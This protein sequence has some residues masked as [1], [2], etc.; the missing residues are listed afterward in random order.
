MLD[1][2]NPSVYKQLYR[3]AKAKLKLRIKATING[4]V[5]V[6]VEITQPNPS[7]TVSSSTS[8]SKPS[9][10]ATGHQLQES[11]RSKLPYDPCASPSITPPRSLLDTANPMLKLNNPDDNEKSIDQQMELILLEQ[12]SKKRCLPSQQAASAFRCSLSPPLGSTQPGSLTQRLNAS[13]AQFTICC[14]NCDATIPDIHWHCG[15]CDN[16]DF[17][18]CKDC[19]DKG[20]VCD[21]DEHWLIKR[22][23]KN[24]Q[25]VNSTTE[26]AELKNRDKAELTDKVP[27]AFAA[28]EGK[29]K[30]TTSLADH[31][32]ST[33]TCNACV[34]GET[35]QR[36]NYMDFC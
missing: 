2:K 14:N 22:D 30:P 36:S 16:G 6:A 28:P 5:P 29:S 13:G 4:S 12:E 8:E 17:D 25:V 18:L 11:S 3:A 20:F 15:I 35:L 10:G 27:G 24:G 9:Y 21:S 31:L 1:S 7:N 32:S 33:R 23:V 19:V 26:T 34:G